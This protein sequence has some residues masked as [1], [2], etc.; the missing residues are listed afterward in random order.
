MLRDIVIQLRRSRWAK[1]TALFGFGFALVGSGEHLLAMVVWVILCVALMKARWTGQ[2]AGYSGLR[3]V[4]ICLVLCSGLAL[5]TYVRKG[6][7]PW[8]NFWKLSGSLEVKLTP[9]VVVHRRPEKEGW[10]LTSEY[11]FSVVLHV[12]NTTSA[13][14]H[15][16]RLEVF[17]DVEARFDDYRSL[18]ARN[19]SSID[20]I[21]EQ[22]KRVRP[23]RRLHWVAYPIEPVRVDKSGDERYA[24]F[25]FLEPEPLFMRTRPGEYPAR[26]Y[27]G[28]ISGNSEPR[29]PTTSVHIQDLVDFSGV[30]E[31]DTREEV[32]GPKLRQELRGKTFFRVILDGV[33]VS[34][35]KDNINP[36]LWT[37]EKE[38][39]ERSLTNLFRGLTGSSNDRLR[40][41][42]ELVGSGTR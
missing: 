36:V 39:R 35:P 27:F 10:K 41:E 13:A 2:F 28:S 33:T 38:W 19:G 20:E 42:N 16:L 24:K 3:K 26:E 9:H 25:T 30:P 18:M 31:S 34:V 17:G 11:G 15:I 32:T 23:Y 37:L 12:R 6:E 1:G 4:L 40:L 5:W 14:K 7:E 8:T 29:T 21:V 22:Y